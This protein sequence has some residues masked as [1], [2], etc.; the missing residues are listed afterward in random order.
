MDRKTRLEYLKD[1]NLDEYHLK[2]FIKKS[3]KSK[4]EV[5][6]GTGYT[7][8]KASK[9]G[10]FCNSLM[11]ESGSSLIEKYPGLFKNLFRDVKLSGIKV[12]SRTYVSIILFVGVSS[13]VLS[14]LVSFLFFMQSGVLGAIFKAIMVGV[15]LGLVGL[16]VAYSYPSSIAS[17]RKRKIRSEIPFVILHMSAVAGSGAQPISIFHSLL[18]T[19]EYKELGVEVKKIVNYVN[20]FGY[21]FTT[22]LRT[23]ANTTPSLDFK[24][25]LNGI[26]ATVE[27]GGD[28]KNYLNQKSIESLNQYKLDRDK[29]VKSL[30]TYSDV[31]TGLLIAAP[32][33]FMVSLA[34]I[35]VLGGQIGGFSV[36]QIAGFGTYAALP[37]LNVIFFIFI[38]IV[39]PEI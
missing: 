12:L 32:L 5:E 19:D 2:R 1:I 25:L 4:E 35:N 3:K 27:S 37:V 9:F 7:L 39:S 24:E 11:G 10:K 22:A 14:S 31:Y 26:V 13:F 8:Y 23:V 15:V 34:I 29:Y 21:D 36:A 30:S 6:L 33:L 16:A 38:N 18:E 28:L 17:R 20:L